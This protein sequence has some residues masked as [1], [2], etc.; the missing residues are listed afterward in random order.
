MMINS[1]LVAA[2]HAVR[3]NVSQVIGYS[4]EAL[5]FHK[6][7]LSYVSLVIYFLQVRTEKQMTGDESL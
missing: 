4:P 6:D 5:S 1:A 7:M 3:T 2:S